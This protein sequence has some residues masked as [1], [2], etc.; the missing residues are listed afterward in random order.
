MGDP[1]RIRGEQQGGGA[2]ESVDREQARTEV[3][4]LNRLQATSEIVVATAV[5]LGIVYFAKLP[6]IVLLVSVLLAFILAPLVDLF[7]KLRL[8]RAA[9]SLIATLLLIGALYGIF[10]VSF[11][12]AQAFAG[13]LPKYSGEIR[14]LVVH[15]RQKAEKIEKS[16]KGVLPG[17][18]THAVTVEPVSVWQRLTSNWGALA[19]TALIASFIPFLVYF[20][21]SWQE[22]ARARTVKLFRQENQ[23]TAYVTMGQISS[24]IRSFIV[25]NVLVG[26]FIG[27]VSTVIFGLIGLPYFY[28]LGVIS[29]FLSLVPYLG[30]LL[31][32]VPPIT[33]GLGHLHTTGIVIILVTVLGLHLFALNVL[34]P[35]F[36][37]PRIRLNPLAVTL[38]LLFWGWMWGAMGL[39]LAIPITGAM[40]IIFDH[41]DPLKQAGAWLG[42]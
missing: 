6:L 41:I 12:Q 17:P 5:V 1:V 15:V 8:P 36:L 2:A 22:H 42:E 9:G 10:Y 3:R 35:K 28:F 20:M 19:E 23:K 4:K 25:G 27:G 16:T 40:K 37:G 32:V 31:A 30:V 24:M 7:D 18:G 38:A 29:G 11:T 39:V 33:A 13:E 26:L 14:K 21:L 34:Y